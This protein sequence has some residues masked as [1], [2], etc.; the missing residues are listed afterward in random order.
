MGAVQSQRVHGALQPGHVAMVIGAPDVDDLIEAANGK[1]VA[2]IGDIGGKIG[3]EPIGP[4]Q[5]VILQRQLF[6][7]G[8]G[9]AR[10]PEIFRQDLCRLEPQRT[11]LFVGI[12]LCCQR[13]HRVG[14]IAALVEGGLEKPL[15]I[16]D[17]IALQIPL[18]LGDIAG[19]AELRQGIV[20]GLFVAVQV[21]FALLLIE[22]LRQLPDIVAVVAV[23]G[24]LHRVLALDDLEIPG[25]KAL[26][27]LFDLIAGVIDIELTP[28]V[29]TGLFQ[30]ACQRVAQ[31]AA[32]G[33]AHMH[34]AGGIGGDELHHDLL[35]PQH[36]AVSVV[37]PGRFNGGHG[38]AEPLVTQPE[39][40]KAG[41]CDLHRGK[42]AVFQRHMLRQD[43]SHLA[44]IHL[45][46]LGRRQ[47]E[48]G[49]IVAVGHVL[50][51][52]HRRL[53]RHALRQQPLL[54]SGGI[55]LL[56]QLLHLFLGLLDHI[57]IG[58]LSLVFV[59]IHFQHP[60]R[61]FSEKLRGQ[62]AEIA[63]NITGIQGNAAL[64][65]AAQSVTIRQG[66]L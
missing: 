40:H 41:A 26:G 57:H 2:V 47:T 38:V 29:R 5:H 55:R 32:A 16:P 66:R 34:G 43:G 49:G 33:V 11:V 54:Y 21:L 53:H 20:A 13:R 60:G 45:H 15:V 24:E 59:N 61:R 23:L 63:G 64:P 8:V 28:H 1:F 4:A 6:N 51:D 52:L 42:I 31:H 14:H 9:L 10:F 27:E 12:A 56:C 35:P 58:S 48:G 39:V 44:G 65:L 19:K 30:Y 50:G 62:R 25:L 37:L 3:V 17:P 7:V 36:I 18:H 46:G 22:Q